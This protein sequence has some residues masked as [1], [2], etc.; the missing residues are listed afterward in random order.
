M[1]RRSI[2]K[3]V[4]EKPEFFGDFLIFQSKNAENLLLKVGI[5][6]TD[7]SAA[8]FISVENKVIGP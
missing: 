2:G 5:E 6:D 3:G 7:A 1:W 8:Y 4:C